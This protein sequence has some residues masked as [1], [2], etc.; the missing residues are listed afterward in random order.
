MPRRVAA[1]KAAAAP[2]EVVILGLEKQYKELDQEYV[3]LSARE[4]MCFDDDDDTVKAERVTKF[5]TAGI[6]F[7]KPLA[8]IP[9]EITAATD[10]TTDS[11]FNKFMI[12]VWNMLDITESG[13]VGGDAC[14]QRD[15]IWA[16]L[17][18]A[19][20]IQNPGSRFAHLVALVCA[21]RQHEVSSF[22]QR[23]EDGPD[24]DDQRIFTLLGG[25]FKKLFNLKD[26][27]RHVTPKFRD[28]A[29]KT[30]K[31]LQGY[32]K[33]YGNKEYAG[34]YCSVFKF[35]FGTPQKSSDGGGPAKKRAKKA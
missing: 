35:N 4:Q 1:P 21:V 2:K 17:I 23:S 22:I 27:D 7:S 30:C 5:E 31:A 3:Q 18:D 25:E 9:A 11:E 13:S 34:T 8:E 28:Y 6:D 26:F 20:N 12:L 14:R 19:L 33:S 10:I 32:L 24:G 16:A 15:V 29:I